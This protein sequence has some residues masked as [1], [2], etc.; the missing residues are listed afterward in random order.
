[1]RSTVVKRRPLHVVTVDHHR[2]SE[3]HQPGW[4]Y[5]DPTLVDAAVGRVDTLPGFRR[6]TARAD[7]EDVVVGVIARSEV[8][9]SLWALP[10]AFLFLDGSHKP[11]TG[12]AGAG[13]A[14]GCD[15]CFVS[16]PPPHP[17]KHR[18]SMLRTVNSITLLNIDVLLKKS[19]D[20]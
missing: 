11:E 2:G 9:A 1:M 7:V 20:D 14:A 6:T 4:D 16:S 8:F 17:A 19:D 10:V 12:F 13:A 5:H 3:E 15:A 18:M